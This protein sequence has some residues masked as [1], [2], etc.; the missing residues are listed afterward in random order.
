MS[1][2]RSPRPF[3]AIPPRGLSRSRVAAG[4]VLALLLPPAL[5]AVL[6]A[7][8]ANL[9]TA[10]LAQLT[11]GVLVAIVGGIWPALVAAA[12]SALLLNYFMTDPRGTFVISEPQ[13]LVDLVFFVVV[14]GAV[15][16]I[17]DVSA[18]R[19]AVARQAGAEAAALSELALVAVASEDPIRG[20]LEQA[21][22]VLG[23]EGVALFVRRPHPADSSGADWVLAESTGHAPSSPREADVVQQVNPGT[24]LVLT[25]HR[26]SAA[27]HR[28]LGAFS[29]QVTAAQAR[30]QL[31]ASDRENKRLARDNRMRTSILRAVSHDLRTPLAGIK[32]SVESLLH[33][34]ARLTAGERRELLTTT[35]GYADRLALLVENLLDMSRI[36]SDAVRVLVEPTEWEDVLAGALR[37]V[38]ADTVDIDIAPRLRPIAADRGLL[39]RVI[40]NVAENAARHAPGSR[41]RLTA[42]NAAGADGTR[43]GELRV[44]DSG[45]APLPVDLEELFRA[46][47]RDTDSGAGAGVGLGLAVAR[48]LTEAMHGSLH[49]ERTEGGGLTMVL[50]M[51]V[52]EAETTTRAEA[53]SA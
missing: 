40:A 31:A 23:M 47:Q 27:E 50:R 53:M 41:I 2:A 24:L 44:A 3:P 15:A 38:P 26:L 6:G 16:L 48:G 10:S 25:G 11:G 52:A 39:E 12:W 30:Q 43:L 36:S 1:E 7:T 49:A 22:Q 45:S 9:T 13:V 37:G 4:L 33:A 42:R 8:N 28:L 14:S 18:R 5:Q 19:S 34:G 51:P 46:F 35:E 32:L 21:K 20:L 29:A 17:V